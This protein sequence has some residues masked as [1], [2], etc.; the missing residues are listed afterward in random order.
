[1]CLGLEPGVSGCKAQTNPLSYCGTPIFLSKLFLICHRPLCNLTDHLVL[2][3]PIIDLSVSTRVFKW[4]IPG[5]FF[6]IFAFSTVQRKNMLNIKFQTRLVSNPG[7]LLLEATTVPTCH[8]HFPFR[9]NI[10]VTEMKCVL[11]RGIIGVSAIIQLYCMNQEIMPKNLDTISGTISQCQKC[12]VVL[13]VRKTP[14][15]RLRYLKRT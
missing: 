11:N 12:L 5:L 9:G 1:M 2:Y 14:L 3:P 13:T 6:Y 8:N 7:P 10:L 15:P 4:A